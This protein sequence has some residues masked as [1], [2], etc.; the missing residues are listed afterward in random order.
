MEETYGVEEIYDFKGIRKHFSRLGLGFFLGTIIIYAV[1]IVVEIII[2]IFRLDLPVDV[3]INIILSA[4]PMYL[5]GMPALIALARMVP[6]QK[7]EKRPM[8]VW[9]FIVAVIMSFAIMYIF[10]IV[11]TMITDIIGGIKGGEVENVLESAL[12]GASIP[13]VFVYTV[14]CAP[15]MEEYVF[16]KL[17]VDRTVR[18]GQGVAVLL[19]GLMFGLFHGNLNQFAYTFCLGMFLAFIYVKT[20]NLKITIGLHMLVNIMGGVV[21][22]VILEI[23]D[24]DA[25]AAILESG[26]D[27]TVLYAF[28]AENIGGLLMLLAYELLVYGSMLVGGIL[29]IAALVRKQF[30]LAPGEEPIP[31][32]ARFRTVILN[33]GM[34]LYCLIWVALIVWQ[35]FM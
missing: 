32:G 30:Q 13:L 26:A 22:M 14:I 9:H 6:A 23:L 18:Y 35:L 28:V 24:L 34:L 8:K 20:G 1:Q 19:S 15:I 27:P 2:L 25:L 5:I 33:P 10:N 11:G 29:L 16:R 4:V 21:G 3:N 12:S 17:I 7:P 31:R